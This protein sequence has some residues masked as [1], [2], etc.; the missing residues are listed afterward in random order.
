MSPHSELKGSMAVHLGPGAACEEEARLEGLLGDR[1]ELGN[2]WIWRRE[3]SLAER[4]IIVIKI[5]Y[6]L[7]C[8]RE[9]S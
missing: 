1:L 8:F 4:C 5:V 7:L 3:K 2:G 9:S 6:I